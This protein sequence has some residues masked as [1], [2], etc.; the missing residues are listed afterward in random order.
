MEL[1]ERINVDLKDAMRARDKTRLTAIR[2]LR[3]E[4]LKIEK[5]GADK[6]ATDDAVVKA[7][8]SLIKQRRD[9]IDQ[10]TKGGRDELAAQEKAEMAVL[11][12]Y[13]PAQLSDSEAQEL[14]EQAIAQVGA[15]SLK[16]MGKTMGTVQKLLRD[17]GKDADNRM[18]ADLIKQRLSG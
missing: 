7:A 12:G 9:A 4:V 8:K 5:S 1:K 15:E 13:L 14:V 6:E 11:E 18:L 16:D 10:F 2:A 17:T 3:G